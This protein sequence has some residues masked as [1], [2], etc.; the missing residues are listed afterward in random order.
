ML[1]RLRVLSRMFGNGHINASLG[2]TREWGC[3]ATST[4]QKQFKKA[5]FKPHMSMLERLNARYC[6][7]ISVCNL[8]SKR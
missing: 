2:A 4:E 7:T 5:T 3:L 1:R 6:E 8:R